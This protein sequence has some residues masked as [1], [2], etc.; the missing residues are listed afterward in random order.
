MQSL[1]VD[2]LSWFYF[3]NFFREEDVKKVDKPKPSN[4]LLDL[5]DLNFGNPVQQQPPPPERTSAS[6]TVQASAWGAVPSNSKQTGNDPWGGDMITSGSD[7]WAPP[8]HNNHHST[9]PSN[10][11]I[12]N[13]GGL[14]AVFGGMPQNSAHSKPAGICLY[15]SLFEL[16]PGL[17]LMLFFYALDIY[18]FMTPAT[19]LLMTN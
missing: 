4:D 19:S 1:D 17:F 3:S 15:R 9:G 12:P 6:S 14:G 13:M 8:P 2:L 18:F 5:A 7:P 10:S 16:Q 11:P